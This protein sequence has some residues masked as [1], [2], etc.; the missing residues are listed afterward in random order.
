MSL[1]I[2]MFLGT[3]NLDILFQ[4]DTSILP[5]TYIVNIVKPT[6]VALSFEIV[7]T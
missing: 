1:H 2:L 3:N 7:Q 5:F 6:K 4:N